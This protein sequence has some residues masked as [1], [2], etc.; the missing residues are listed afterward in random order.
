MLATQFFGFRITH[1]GVVVIAVHR[2]NFGLF[3]T[4]W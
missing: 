2:L 4:R 3:A 1:V